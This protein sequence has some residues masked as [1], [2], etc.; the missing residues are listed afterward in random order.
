MHSYLFRH[1]NSTISGDFM[2]WSYNKLW[3]MLIH[4]NLK[5]TDLLKLAGINSNALAHMGKNEPIAMVALGKICQAL[6]CNIEDIVEYVPDPK[7]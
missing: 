6:E 4:K 2:G 3:I 7:S 5:R 1:F